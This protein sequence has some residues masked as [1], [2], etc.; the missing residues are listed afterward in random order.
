[1]RHSTPDE[2]ERCVSLYAGG[3]LLKHLEVVFGRPRPTIQRWIRR[4]GKKR[5]HKFRGCWTAPAELRA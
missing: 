2:R 5:G 3:A 4:A 1:M